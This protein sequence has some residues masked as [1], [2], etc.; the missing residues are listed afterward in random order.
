MTKFG[1]VTQVGKG[2]FLGVR[3]A[4]I[5]RGGRPQIFWN[6]TYSE[7]SWPTGT[8]LGTVTHLR[9]ERISTG[10]ATPIPKGA[11]PQRPKNIGTLYGY[12][13]TCL[14]RHCTLC[15]ISHGGHWTRLSIRLMPIVFSAGQAIWSSTINYNVKCKKTSRQPG[16]LLEQ[17]PAT[18]RSQP[19]WLI[20]QWSLLISR[21]ATHC[22]KI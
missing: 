14:S 18:H 20:N 2:A 8:K 15:R 10:S 22:L 5:P 3:L 21:E 4:H 13:C 11:G 9:H 12:R 6:P 17:L 7:T 19:N 1:T 16:G